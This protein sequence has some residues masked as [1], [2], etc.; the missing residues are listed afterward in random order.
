MRGT[1]NELNVKWSESFFIKS[2]MTGL[3]FLT[4]VVN[5]ILAIMKFAEGNNIYAIVA[6]VLS[7]VFAVLMVVFFHCAR[8][9]RILE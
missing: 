4:A 8:Y 3:T 2:I 5:L 6:I 1:E 7:V 9:K